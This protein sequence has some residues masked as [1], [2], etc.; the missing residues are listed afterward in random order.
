[1]GRPCRAAAATASALTVGFRS[2]S[3]VVTRLRNGS[4]SWLS[5]GTAECAKTVVRAGSIPAAR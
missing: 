1:M 4:R 2:I 3:A 5:A